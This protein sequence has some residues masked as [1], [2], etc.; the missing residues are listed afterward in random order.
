M[1][2]LSR[3][4]FMLS[5]LLFLLLIS[6]S[7]SSAQTCD[8]EAPLL[9]VSNRTAVL[10]D[11]KRSKDP[12]STVIYQS[13]S[14]GTIEQSRFHQL[15]NTILLLLNY[16]N[17]TYSIVSL[18]LEKKSKGKWIEQ[19]YQISTSSNVYLSASQRYVYLFYSQTKRLQVTPLPITANSFED[20]VLSNVPSNQRVVDYHVDERFH[21][22]WI[23]FDGSPYSLYMCQ[24]Q[25][26]SCRLF[27]NLI[28]TR[29][30]IQFLI[31]WNNQQLI[32]SSRIHLV[33][34][35][36]SENRTSYSVQYHNT[37]G[38]D[39]TR[40]LVLCE[41][42]NQLDFVSMNDTHPGQVCLRQCF[43]LPS[44]INETNRIHTIQRLGKGLALRSCSNP[45]RIIRTVVLLLILV[46][47]IVLLAVIAWL[48][49]RYLLPRS[50]DKSST[51]TSNGTL[52][53]VGKDLV[54]HF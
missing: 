9:L 45:H 22:L 37:T 54:T 4:V 51:G 11:T 30:P 35:D 26:S 17:Q 10:L 3:F 6:A 47:L 43:D 44:S 41:K 29:P 1:S 31:N 34:F 52:S 42:S 7:I 16:R 19:S 32:I 18:N 40:Y 20:R 14:N 8:D 49:Y 2:S 13:K 21:F 36:Y 25:S 38:M 5:P 46:D 24:L 28:Q 12:S 15:T 33:L 27:I 53:I 50:I 23:L 39:L 48:T